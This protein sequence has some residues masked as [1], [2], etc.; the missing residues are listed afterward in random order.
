MII[1]IYSNECLAEV[2]CFTPND[3]PPLWV[4]VKWSSKAM[5]IE[6]PPNSDVFVG[7]FFVAFSVVLGFLPCVFQLQ[8]R[9]GRLEMESDL[10]FQR[11]PW[12]DIQRQ[13]CD[14]TLWVP[15]HKGFLVKFGGSDRRASS[16]EDYPGR[17]SSQEKTCFWLS[18]F[19]MGWYHYIHRPMLTAKFGW[20]MLVPL[21]A[22]SPKK[23]N[24]W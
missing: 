12:L 7:Q 21:L 9:Y 17:F 18:S 4:V 10:L 8:S 6:H 2:G 5:A 22:F 1:A 11:V 23:T 13:T 16:R 24:W 20:G 3:L 19:W 14:I 15:N